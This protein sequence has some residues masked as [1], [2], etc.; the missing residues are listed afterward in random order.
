MRRLNDRFPWSHNDHFH[1]WIVAGLPARRRGAI[2]V[3]C[4]QGA[5]LARLAGEFRH[6]HGTDTSAAMR[7]D[8]RR[9]C[10][11]L[12]NVTIDAAQ[13]RDLEP[14]TEPEP[15]DLIT[16]VAALHHLD[17]EE[18]F[19]EAARLLSPGG[20]LLVV[21]LA[22]SATPRDF[23][24][25]GISVVT[26]PLIGMMKNA[27]PRRGGERVGG[28]DVDPPPS[29]RPRDPF[30][31]TDPTMTFDEIAEAARRH[32]PGARLRHRVGFRYTLEWTKPGR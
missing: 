19:A 10:A 29:E 5:L 21:G 28:P 25:E 32:L 9:R 1:P 6:V 22:L 31:V 16:M 20:R 2:E 7:A 15:I 17:V 27:P 18:T 4:G 11:G 3:G 30:P 24:W 8:S 14:D 13:L 12:G 26:N 23:L